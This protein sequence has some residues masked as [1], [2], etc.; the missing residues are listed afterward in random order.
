MGSCLG[1]SPAVDKAPKRKSYDNPQIDMTKYDKRGQRASTLA[2]KLSKLI[3]FQQTARNSVVPR[4][5]PRSEEKLNPVISEK[6]IQNQPKLAIPAKHSQVHPKPVIPAKDIE[7]QPN[8]AIPSKHSHV[9]PKPSI[10]AKD[11]QTQP[12][13]TGQVDENDNS[14]YKTI[15]TWTMEQRKSGVSPINNQLTSQ[16]KLDKSEIPPSRLNDR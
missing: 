9:Q 10:Q 2:E 13:S 14:V 15:T 4:L 1:K 3:M 11:N 7:I 16:T 8:L 12:T 5:P 6:D